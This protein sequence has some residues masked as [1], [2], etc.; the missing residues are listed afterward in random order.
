MGQRQVPGDPISGSQRA[1]PQTTPPEVEASTPAPQ[2]GEVLGERD[3]VPST[4]CRD[5]RSIHMKELRGRE[6]G[7]S[8]RAPGVARTGL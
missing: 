7:A 1:S 4:L 8:I 6:R 5:G 3:L 2:G